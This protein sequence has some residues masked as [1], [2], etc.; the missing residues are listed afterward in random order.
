MVGIFSRLYCIN[1]RCSEPDVPLERTTTI[2]PYCHSDILIN[3][4]YRA[5]KILGKGGFGKTYEVIDIKNRYQT[6]NPSRKVLKILLNNHP[7]AIR[8]FQREARV[9][10]RLKHPGIPDVEEG[11]YF[12]LWLEDSIEPLYCLVMEFIAGETLTE[13]LNSQGIL[14]LNLAI[15]W[16]KQLV[17]ILHQVHQQQYFHRDIKPDNIMLK[18]DGQLVLIDFGAVREVTDTFLA[19][20][21]VNE[22][23]T[24]V[25]SGGYTPPEQL[26]GSAVP[27]SDFYALGRTFVYLLTGTC[28]TAF[29]QD[30]SG[31][32][33][34][35]D[36]VRNLSE[37]LADLLDWMMQPVVGWRPKNTQEILDYLQK[38]WQRHRPR[39]KVELYWRK[40]SRVGLGILTLL[41]LGFV[42]FNW[43]V[44]EL[45][46]YFRNRGTRYHV[47]GKL[48]LAQE[49]FRRSLFL[50][51]NSLETWFNLG[52][53][54]D[55]LGNVKQAREAYQKAIER[56][57]PEA[58][59]NLARLEILERNYTEAI[60]LVEAGLALN[61]D[62]SVNYALI[63]NLGWIYWERRDYAKAKTYLQTA[64]DLDREKAAAYCLL[65]QVLEAEGNPSN[66]R[67]EWESCRR[68]A[69]PTHIDEKKWRRESDRRLTTS[70]T[71]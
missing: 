17:E 36:S 3:N 66:A 50:T 47:A 34:W 6:N 62:K 2:C 52:R 54:Y 39:I 30:S 10:A 65:A 28:P 38:D 58:Y 18:P 8:L 14:D 29:K 4:R 9:L 19:K 26:H 60:A 57:L 31:Q 32:L 20:V 24:R 51:P 35:R 49:E 7:D 44:Q 27:Q 23:I 5:I 21:A 71:L 69:S 11:G 43:G 22:S 42:G 16:L 59:S 67:V 33:L 48:Y 45:S 61:P 13:W 15:D 46:T 37:S 1:P 70:E 56:N 64:I 41:A 25:V 40:L 68:Y 12:K 53:N 63:K 55:R